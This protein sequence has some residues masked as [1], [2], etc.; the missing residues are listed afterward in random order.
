M[1]IAASLS[2]AL[3]K[4]IRHFAQ[5]NKESIPTLKKKMR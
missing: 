2:F 1:S 5:R 3:E 4:E